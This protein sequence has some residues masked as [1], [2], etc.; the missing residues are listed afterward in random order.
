MRSARMLVVIFALLFSACA[1]ITSAEEPKTPDPVGLILIQTMNMVRNYN[2]TN[3][4]LV[5]RYALKRI[6]DARS[7]YL[8]R[9][10]SDKDQEEHINRSE[11]TLEAS[12]HIIFMQKYREAGDLL[13]A[14]QQLVI[15][16]HHASQSFMSPEIWKEACEEILMNLRL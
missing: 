8:S 1:N 4:V 3:R 7:I 6:G 16:C 9:K 11:H 15:A 5:L 12:L 10:K 14:Q 2:G 13:G